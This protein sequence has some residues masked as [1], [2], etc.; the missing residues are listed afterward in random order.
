MTREMVYG[1]AAGAAVDGRKHGAVDD[2]ETFL[3]EH[4]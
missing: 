4:R 2:V 3:G 1:V